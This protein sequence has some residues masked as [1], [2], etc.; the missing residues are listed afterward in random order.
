M[1]ATPDKGKPDTDS[2]RINFDE[3][4]R[5][6]AQKSPS[7]NLTEDNWPKDDK[8]LFPDPKSIEAEDG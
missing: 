6:I 5:D 3:E 8:R 4:P 1:M 2:G 7:K